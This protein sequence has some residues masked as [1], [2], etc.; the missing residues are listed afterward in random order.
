M[1][2]IDALAIGETM[3]MVA[4]RTPGPLAFDTAF[5]L[6]TGGAES[7]VAI[8]LARLGHGSA[9]A[10]AVGDDPFGRMILARLS[11]IGVDVSH[12]TTHATTPT[13]VYFKHVENES[14][15]VLYYRR[16]SAAST[17]GPSLADELA[18]VA[19]RV[20]HLTGITAAISTSCRELLESLLIDRRVRADCVSFDVNYR[21][22]LWSTA[23]AAPVLHRLAAAADAVFVGLDEAR[24]LWGAV[25]ADA[26]RAI[27]PTPRYLVV[28]DHANGATEFEHDK[29]V[30]VAAP[31]VDVVESVGAGDAFAAGWLSALLRGLDAE[32]RVALGHR[33][34]GHVL[35]TTSDD[36]ALPDS[37]GVG[38]KPVLPE[39]PHGR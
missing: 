2:D 39:H 13:G 18:G 23:E 6:H 15:R 17:L 19:P 28:K 27:L 32:A 37:L 16:G 30:H 14:T 4:P 3:V 11:D 22:A 10:G 38:P 35:R 24:A 34:A 8:H 21:P 12:A 5:E 9:W 31:P 20:L 25:D 26:V 33:V 7:N 29:R 1:Q 36:V